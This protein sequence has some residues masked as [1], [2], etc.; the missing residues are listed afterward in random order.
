G[1]EV[2][3]MLQRLESRYGAVEAVSMGS[4]IKFCLVADGS[5]DFYPRLRP[6]ME[7]DTAAAHAV[8]RGVGGEV[9]QLDGKPLVYNKDDLLNPF[10]VAQSAQA[11]VWQE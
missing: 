11:V 6:T 7:W 9:L 1:A 5:A 10:F 3:A 4:S 8:L 2:E